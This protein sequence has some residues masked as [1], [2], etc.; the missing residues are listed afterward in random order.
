MSIYEELKRRGYSSRM[1][2]TWHLLKAVEMTR[3]SG[4]PLM[5]TKELYPAI[6]RSMGTTPAAVERSIRHSISHAE[7]G[8]TNAEV[9]RDVAMGMYSHED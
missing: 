2:G 1:S 7:P 4:R 5:M 9:I 3:Q 8:R 6:A